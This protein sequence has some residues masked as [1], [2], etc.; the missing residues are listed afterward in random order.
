MREGCCRTSS[1]RMCL[2]IDGWSPFQGFPSNSGE[3][4][5]E[6]NRVDNKF[7]YH[8]RCGSRWWYFNSRSSCVHPVATKCHEEEI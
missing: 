2:I 3:K 1:I 7:L 6:D 5:N 8:Q 4:Y